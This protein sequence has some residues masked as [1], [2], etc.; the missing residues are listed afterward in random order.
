MLGISRVTLIIAAVLSIVAF[1]YLVLAS[2]E[3]S[4]GSR[5][6]YSQSVSLWASHLLPLIPLLMLIVMYFFV[7]LERGIA[8]A[9]KRIAGIFKGRL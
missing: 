4:L 7:D 1:E 6:G 2:G 8:L 9:E 3:S 5:Y